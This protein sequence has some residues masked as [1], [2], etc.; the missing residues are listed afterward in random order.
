MNAAV[1]ATV[2]GALIASALLRGTR[3]RPD[4]LQPDHLGAGSRSDPGTGAKRQGPGVGRDPQVQAAAPGGND[5]VQR[6][7]T[8]RARG[9]PAAADLVPTD[10]AWS[11]RLL[12]SAG[13]AR[14]R[15]VHGVAHARRHADPDIQPDIGTARVDG[16][17]AEFRRRQLAGGDDHRQRA[18]RSGGAPDGSRLRCPAPPLVP[19]RGAGALQATDARQPG[20]TAGEPGVSRRGALLPR[21]LRLPPRGADLADARVAGSADARGSGRVPSRALPARP[22]RARRRRRCVD[23][24]GADRRGVEAWRVDQAAGVGDHSR[25]GAGTGQRV[26]DLLRRAAELGSD[27]PARRRSG[28]RAH[29]CRLRRAGGDEQDHRRRRDGA[30][31]PPS[32]RGEGL[33]LR[34]IERPRCTAAP[35]RLDRLDQRPHRSDRAGAARSAGGSAAASRDPGVGSGTCRRQAIDGGVVRALARVAGTAAEPLPHAVAVQAAGRLLGSLRGARHGGD[36][37]AGAGGGAAISRA[38]PPPDCGGRRSRHA[39]STR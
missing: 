35:R 22:R 7:S 32:A 5:V 31:V 15:G 33:H 26:E 8:D 2:A 29:E 23:V 21:R 20:A 12:R 10:R 17:D 9:P 4:G 28:D 30:T 18:Q 36:Q 24:P 19:R 16:G 3:L 37:G 11:G 1:R 6:A 13:S 38:G 39:R 25:R 27:Q 34:S 14:S